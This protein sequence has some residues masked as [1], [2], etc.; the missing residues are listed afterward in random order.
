MPISTKAFCKIFAEGYKMSEGVTLLEVA[1]A[2][3]IQGLPIVPLKGKQPLA[4]WVKWQKQT[5][6]EEELQSLP[7][8]KADG[9]AIVC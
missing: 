4:D 1:K 2:Y 6:T 5:Q 8:D 3:R 7:W 9:F